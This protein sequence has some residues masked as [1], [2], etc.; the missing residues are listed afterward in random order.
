MGAFFG[1][2]SDQIDAGPYGLNIG[3]AFQIV[4]DILDI[5]GEEASI[6][7]HGNGILDSR[8]TFPYDRYA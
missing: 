5:D 7:N 1:K 4:D 2:G 8:R 6:G 3:Y